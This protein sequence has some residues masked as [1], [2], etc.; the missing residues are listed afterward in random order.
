LKFGKEKKFQV[1]SFVPQVTHPYPA[2]AAAAASPAA[3]ALL[4]LYSSSSAAAMSRAAAELDS[5]TLR[6]LQLQ[7]LPHLHLPHPMLHPGYPALSPFASHHLKTHFG[8]FPSKVKS[9]A[10]KP[11]AGLC[12]LLT[13]FHSLLIKE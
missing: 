3:A 5:E 13:V 6:Q 8:P 4:Q 11:F 9:W 7:H 2:A 10:Q 1:F 12:S